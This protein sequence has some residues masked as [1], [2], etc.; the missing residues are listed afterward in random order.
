MSKVYYASCFTGAHCSGVY[1]TL[2]KAQQAIED[3]YRALKN[4]PETADL[5]MRWVRFHDAWAWIPE[6]F[7][8]EQGNP[9]AFNNTPDGLMENVCIQLHTLDAALPMV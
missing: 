7:Q 3:H 1:A 2:E 5:D 9:W 8:P 6:D 4:A